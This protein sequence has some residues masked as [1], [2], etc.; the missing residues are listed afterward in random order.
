MARFEPDKPGWSLLLFLALSLLLHL[1]LLAWLGR[2]RLSEDREAPPLVVKLAAP[3]AE[4]APAKPPAQVPPTAA[5]PQ[6]REQI[7]APSDQENELPPLGRAY[8]SDRDNRVEQETVRHGNPEAGTPNVPEQEQTAA[9]ARPAPPPAPPPAPQAAPKQ[10]PP[11][12]APAKKPP[13]RQARAEPKRIAPP[14]RTA[15]ERQARPVQPPRELPGLDRLL[16]PPGEVLA[17]VRPSEGDSGRR[18]ADDRADPRRDLVSAPP[19]APG[20]FAG[21]RGTFDDLPDVSAGNLTMLNTK[22]DRFAPFVRRVGTRV[23]QNLLIYQ[24]R[25]LD[26]PEILAANGQVTVRALLDPGG[27]LKDLEVVDRSGSHAVDQT[28]LDA[29]KE[30]AFDHNPPKEAANDDGDFEFLFQAQLSAGV[31]PGGG[32]IRSIESRLRIGLL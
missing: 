18:S 30:A 14:K 20:L 26:V 10:P 3:P 22:A 29:L 17:K 11:R 19:P 2:S 24:R 8:L 5:A 21:M 6:L 4:P 25:D 9:V 31:A 28:L 13:T 16:P 23:F 27:R 15:P 32:Q 12:S 7:V 1:V